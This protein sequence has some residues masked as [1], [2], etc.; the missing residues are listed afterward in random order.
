[1]GD[2]LREAGR[3]DEALVKYGKAVEVSD[4]ARVPAEA[5]AVTKRN[6][7]FEQSRAAL[8]KHDLGT[9]KTKAAAYATEVAARKAP[10]EVRQQQE[11]EGLIALEE[12]RYADAIQA[13]GKSNQQDPRILYLTALAMKGAGD[14]K[15]S[16]AMGKKAAAFN[17]LSFNYAYVRAKA[18]KM[19]GTH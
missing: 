15:S 14:A 3:I 16:T 1:M 11:I 9:A 12:K 19:D 5:K 10:F 2:I 4:A 18:M 13:F 8:A 7:L 17:Q 6:Y